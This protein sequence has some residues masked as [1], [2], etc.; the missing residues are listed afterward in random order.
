MRE[1]LRLGK[2]QLDSH[3]ES[4]ER[5]LFQRLEDSFLGQIRERHWSSSMLSKYQSARM[6][7]QVQRNLAHILLCDGVI[8]MLDN[9]DDL[10]GDSI[11]KVKSVYTARRKLY[12]EQ[13]NLAEKQ[14]P[15]FYHYYIERL[16]TRSIINSGW[17]H[18]I[19]EFQDDDL[20]AKGFNTIRR[21]V[22][23]HLKY[24]STSTPA[25]VI[26]DS[27]ISKLLEDVELFDDL[28]DEGRAFIEKNATTI[29]FLSGDTII[30]AY[31]K[32]DNFY[33]IVQGKASAWR[34]DAFGYSHRMSEFG[35]GEIMGESSLLA[36]HEHGRHIRTATIKA[37][38]S[39]TVIRI[40]PR[41]MSAILTKYPTVKNALQEIHDARLSN[42]PKIT[43]D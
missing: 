26:G 1:T 35:A 24:I 7:Q 40:A 9:Q 10:D 21:V 30:G 27:A 3:G 5:S 13:L 36:E 15:D 29:T 43:D 39:C 33:I 8:A 25:I 22:D 4:D 2:S 23:K 28:G 19:A 20:G 11:K 31:E 18:V 38:T 32:G 14:F 17:N 42:A 12:R 37:E 16:A 6:V 41:P 34:K